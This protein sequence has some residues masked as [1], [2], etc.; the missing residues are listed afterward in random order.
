MRPTPET[1]YTRALRRDQHDGYYPATRPAW[2]GERPQRTRARDI[3]G[4]VI[5]LGLVAYFWAAMFSLPH[6]P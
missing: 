3:I 1:R 2:R 5:F 4:A 6:H